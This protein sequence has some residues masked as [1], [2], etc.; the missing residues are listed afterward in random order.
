[1]ST[2]PSTR[3]A[4]SQPHARLSRTVLAAGALIT[5]T[6]AALF[7][8]SLAGKHAGTRVQPAALSPASN[9]P[10]IRYRGTGQPPAAP[11]TDSS[12][13]APRPTRLLRAEHS[14]GA[15]P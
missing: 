5:V 11:A 1:M 2:T 13:G 4:Q 8:L 12:L 9:A 7:I 6:I 10:L 14:Y 3:R 15:V